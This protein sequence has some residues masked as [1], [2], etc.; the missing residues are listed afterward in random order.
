MIAAA[1]D[2]RDQ[3]AIFPPVS[4]VRGGMMEVGR[5]SD[6][7]AILKVI[8]E[9]TAAYLRKDFA[10]WARCWLH[11]PHVRRWSWYPNYGIHLSE[12][13]DAES[14]TMRRGME[15]LPVP[16]ASVG[17]V[18]RERMNLRVGADM[19][20]A[21]FDQYA[22]NTG[23]PPDLGSMQHQLRILEK[24]DGVW[25]IVCINALEPW[26]QAADYPVIE[27]DADAKVLWMNDPAS[28]GLRDHGLMLGAGRLRARDR[29]GNKGLQAAI[30]WAAGATDYMSHKAA[31]R[32]VSTIR[33]ALPVILGEDDAAG[34]RVCWV[35]VESDKIVVSFDDG[36][37]TDQRLAAAAVVY[38]LS[39]GQ[40]RLAKMVVE[41]HDLADAARGL[42]ISVNTARTHLQRM[43]DKTG[44]RSQ[45]ALVRVLL[46]AIAPV[47]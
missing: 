43:F 5:D 13:W 9:E 19:A 14:A 1:R 3:S 28:K 44:V 2:C 41:G 33:G 45:P 39:P 34:I 7:A 6:H 22:T 15:Q 42:G 18:R 27:I 29:A 47:A 26:L 4:A 20:W 40:L 21:T 23:D 46:G 12:G 25:K 11:A 8:E 37:R 16:N 38:G 17:S 35:L 24:Q 36:H 32:M 31:R 30:R 10:A